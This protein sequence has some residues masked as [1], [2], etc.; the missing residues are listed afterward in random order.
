MVVGP[1]RSNLTMLPSPDST[2]LI[3]LDA[4]HGELVAVYP[5]GIAEDGQSVK[6]LQLEGLV[7]RKE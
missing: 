5:Q 3:I 4:L 7:G 2:H 6:L 1:S